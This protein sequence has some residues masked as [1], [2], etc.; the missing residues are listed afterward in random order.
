MKVYSV[1]S[2]QK[3][4]PFSLPELPF[5]IDDLSPYF[6]KENFDFHHGK[7]HNAYVLK[8]NE[9]L[10]DK[11]DMHSMSLE[12][13]IITSSKSSAKAIF[14]NAAQIWNHTFYWYSMKKGGGKK[15]NGLLLDKIERDFG[16]YEDF[17]KAF[18]N[19]GVAQFGSGWVW[20]V[21]RDGVLSITHS[22][23]A[24]C[25]ITEGV[26]PI[27]TC[28]VWEHAYYIDYRNRRPDYLSTFIDHL[29]NWDFAEKNLIS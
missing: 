11:P 2:N 28:D 3:N 12:E 16:S 26:K 20:L 7:H 25:P 13:I 8:L 5:G 6:T 1:E 23:N 9:L 10:Q 14:N 24:E 4:Y 18:V 17:K 29:V 21:E 27:I 22:G 19:A 15:P